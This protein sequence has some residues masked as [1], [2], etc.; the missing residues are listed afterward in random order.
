MKR[1]R[2]LTENDLRVIIKESIKRVLNESKYWE[3]DLAATA[4]SMEYWGFKKEAK[5]IEDYLNIDGGRTC[6]MDMLNAIVDVRR[7][8]LEKYNSGE[9]WGWDDYDDFINLL[10]ET[11]DSYIR[12]CSTLNKR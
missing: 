1:V 8:A 11:I 2:K 9:A 5:M 6:N 4:D 7:I 3:S 12:H 10:S